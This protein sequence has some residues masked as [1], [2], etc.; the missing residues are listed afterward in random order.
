[1]IKRAVKNPATFSD[2]CTAM[3][4]KKL[5]QLVINQPQVCTKKSIMSYASNVDRLVAFSCVELKYGAWNIFLPIDDD[6]RVLVIETSLG[7][8]TISTAPHC[9]RIVTVAFEPLLSRALYSRI[10]EENINNVLTVMTSPP[11]LPFRDGYFDKIVIRDIDVIVEGWSVGENLLLIDEMIRTLH[12]NGM[13]IIG[14]SGGKSIE[15]TKGLSIH[16]HSA[17]LKKIVSK[18]MNYGMDVVEKVYPLPGRYALY[19]ITSNRYLPFRTIDRSSLK[20]IVKSYLMRSMVDIFAENTIYIMKR[21]SSNTYGSFLAKMLHQICSAFSLSQGSLVVSK[22]FVGNPNT[23]ICILESTDLKL[24]ARIPLDEESLKRVRNQV[25]ALS[26]IGEGAPSFM[27]Y[28]PHQYQP[29]TISKQ[30]IFLEERIDGSIIGCLE[31]AFLDEEALALEWVKAF[32]EATSERGVLSDDR[33]TELIDAP[34]QNLMAFLKTP[35][36]RHTLLSL[37]AWLKSEFKDVEVPLVCMHGDFKIENIVFD[38]K[39]RVIQGIIDWDLAVLSGLPGIDVIYFLA[40]SEVLRNTG[41]ALSQ[42][43]IDKIFHKQMHDFEREAIRRYFRALCIDEGLLPAL[44]V[45]SWLYHVSIRSKDL[46]KFWDD[47]YA[48]NIE[49]I[50]RQLDV[51]ISEFPKKI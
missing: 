13:L 19:E 45:I 41:T 49:S 38:R 48:L 50:L 39:R 7:L 4:L 34:I 15:L 3:S 5:T 17:P 43:I 35:E 28:I 25:A 30:D 29:I 31:E 47:W 27:K 36:E 51:I 9:S 42:T 12:E 22:I 11:R 14:F 1:M 23:V 44:G 40:Y 33:F 21:R 2:P 37:R 24:I 18:F 26:F 10:A 32:H 6:K 8:D 46:A 16:L 20:T